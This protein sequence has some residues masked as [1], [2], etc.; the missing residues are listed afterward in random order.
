M[1]EVVIV[2]EL[3]R[4]LP[5]V[6]IVLLF[7]LF[8]VRPASRRARETRDMQGA[9]AVGDQVLLTSGIYGTIIELREDR[10]DLEVAPGVTIVVARGAIGAVTPTEATPTTGLE[11]DDNEER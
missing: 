5:I 10:L 6:G 7:W 9:L 8:I 4:L 2:E 11:H 1:F 3:I